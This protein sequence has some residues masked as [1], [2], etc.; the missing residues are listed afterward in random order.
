MKKY[1]AEKTLN[2][3]QMNDKEQ[4]VDKDSLLTNGFPSSEQPVAVNK[5]CVEYTQEADDNSS[6]VQL[7]EIST[8][9]A[10]G[11]VYYILKTERWA[12]DD[13]N[14][15]IKVLQDFEKRLSVNH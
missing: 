7:L 9:D 12:F 8:E 4:K 10:G 13:L 2:K 14:D 11:G 5:V 15:L 1:Q 3:F 6:E